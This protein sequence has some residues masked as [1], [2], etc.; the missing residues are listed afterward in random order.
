MKSAKVIVSSFLKALNEEDFD[1]ARTY[2]SDDLKFR[3]VLRTRDGGDD[4]IA[5]MRK[6]KFKYE[7]L[8]IFHDG[9]D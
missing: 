8:K 4:Y 9:Y 1:K 2:L 7:V 5:D 3:G 6:M